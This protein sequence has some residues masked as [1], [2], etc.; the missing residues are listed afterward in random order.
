MGVMTRIEDLNTVRLELSENRK[1]PLKNAES[2]AR[3]Y[4]ENH[5]LNNHN[6]FFTQGIAGLLVYYHAK[7]L[8]S[9]FG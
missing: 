1:N 5:M 3:K 8:D 7:T 9:R 6:L 2:Y 4:A